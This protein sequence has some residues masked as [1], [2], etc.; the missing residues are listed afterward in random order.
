MNVFQLCSF[1]CGLKS[2]ANRSRLCKRLPS[3]GQKHPL[4]EVYTFPLD[5]QS[6]NNVIRK[7]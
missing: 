5:C 6:S 4:C 1:H 2:V 7:H 3:I